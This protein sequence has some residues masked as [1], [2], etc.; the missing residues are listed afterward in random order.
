MNRT[1]RR[2]H[3]YPNL[4]F[5]E[6]KDLLVKYNQMCKEIIKSA[7]ILFKQYITIKCHNNTILMQLFIFALLYQ[8][9]HCTK[10]NFIYECVR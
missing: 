8:T 4:Y 7:I 9:F 10:Q 3:Q 6:N 1:S 2:C 5:I